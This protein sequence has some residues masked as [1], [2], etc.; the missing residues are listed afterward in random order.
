MKAFTEKRFFELKEI[1]SADKDRLIV[2][3]KELLSSMS[4]IV[5]AYVH[6]SF[7]K[8]KSFRDIDIALFA[9]AKNS[10]YLESGEWGQA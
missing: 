6:G 10:F 7:I 3:I 1:E 4:N 8:S 9:E 2:K 5:F